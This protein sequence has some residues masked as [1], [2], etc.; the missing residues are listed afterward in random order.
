MK[1]FVHPRV[2]FKC[3]TTIAEH[4]PDQNYGCRDQHSLSVMHPNMTASCETPQKVQI[5]ASTLPTKYI[6][7]T[8][9]NI[10]CEYF[11]LSVK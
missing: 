2:K 10:S 11:Q 6:L 9:C 3:L 8:S 4:E 5:P 7:T 1:V